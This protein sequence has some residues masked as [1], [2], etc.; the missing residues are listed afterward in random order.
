[1]GRTVQVD[2]LVTVI[3]LMI[4]GAVLGIVGALLAIPAAALVKL[5]LDE[6][7][8]PRLDRSGHPSESHPEP[9]SEPPA[10][11]EPPE[12][13]GVHAAPISSAARVRLAEVICSVAVFALR[14]RSR[15][16]HR[17]NA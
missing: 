7:A 6:V 1:M 9:P 11:P 12:S 5:L 14:L 13:S 10:R 16:R 17:A 2:G 8:F 4:G 15:R 3:S